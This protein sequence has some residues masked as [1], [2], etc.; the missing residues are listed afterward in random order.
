MNWIGKR[1][2]NKIYGDGTIISQDNGII[3]VRFNSAEEIKRFQCPQ[4]FEKFLTLLD[5][6]DQFVA[7]KELKQ[8]QA[9]T[10]EK[11]QK[12]VQ[13]T[14]KIIEEKQ[15]QRTGKALRKT[16]K[17]SPCQSVEEFYSLF[18]QALSAEIEVLRSE[19]GKKI[20]LRDGRK[21]NKVK[22]Q[23][24]YVFESE[25]ELP[26]PDATQISLWKG[27]ERSAGSILSC[28]EFSVTLLTRQNFGETVSELEIS[29][30]PWRLLSSLIDRLHELLDD[31]S[32]I[33]R[34]LICDGYKEIDYSKRDIITGQINTCE[35]ASSQPITFVW[36]PPGTGK[37]QTLAKIGLES[38]Q[39]G[40]RVLMLAHSNVAVDGAILRVH[41]L[42]QD[43]KPG[44]LVRYG[45]PKQQELL[46]HEYLTSY[47]LALHS[48]PKLKKERGDLLEKQRSHVLN[49]QQSL[50][51][52]TR[53]TEIRTILSEREKEIVRKAQFVATTVSKAAVDSVI[54]NSNFDVVIFD[55]ASM[56]YI[57]Q[58][59]FSASLAKKHFV[60][61]GDFRQL[62]PI[63]QS[64]E[65]SVLNADIFQYCGITS[66][67]D[68]GWS[69]KWLCM[70]D[71]Q[72]RM[73]PQISDLSS[74]IMYGSR[75]KSAE[76]MEQ[77]RRQTATVS[78][79]SGSA[80]ALV[81]LTGMMS[82]CT[83]TK[84]RSRFNVLS[85][86][87]SFA[88]AS[89]LSE[90]YEVGII[91]PYSAQSRLLHAMARDLK[92]REHLPC[93]IS[94]AT[95]H[96][97]QGSEKDVIIYDAVDCYRMA[98]PGMLL[99][100]ME[101][102][103]ANRLFN[104]AL[105]RAKGKFIGVANFAYLKN[106]GLSERL[107][108]QKV[109]RTQENRKIL[110]VEV[111][112]E[113][114]KT[115]RA[116][117]SLFSEQAGYEHFLKD[118][119]QA[120]REI[121]VEIPDYPTNTSYLGDIIQELNEAKRRGVQVYVRAECKRQLPDIVRQIAVENP[122]VA[123]PVALIDKKISWFGEPMSSAQF[124]SEGSTI[125]I[126]TRPIIRFE[127]IHTARLLNSFLG[128]ADTED[129]SKMPDIDQKGKLL[130]DNFANY[131]LQTKKCPVCGR[132]MRL[133][134]S[135]KG[136]FFLSCTGYPTC[137]G[138]ELID[139]DT[140]EKYFY[141]HKKQGQLCT[142]CHYSLEAKMGQYG[143]Y[144]QCCGAQKHKYKLDEI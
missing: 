44:Q 28:E 60:C 10:L 142:K 98:H 54:R 130:T 136:K 37:T 138:T 113:I 128:L 111:L 120:R 114:Q 21:I 81:D 87:I 61:V 40:E 29:A 126:N 23:Y 39:C 67:V 62:P 116:A 41:Q 33:T 101:N 107:M 16:P 104:V 26:Y 141:R 42:S 131:I 38:I 123:D 25:E 134:K 140:V 95:V 122:F 103:Y 115:N 108:F 52:K 19:G 12:A 17:L 59:I 109:L 86:M 91:T 71:T 94:C 121:R 48:C 1:V 13:S 65:S 93:D 15:I 96:Q 32:Y 20:S 14:M 56:A 34:A 89:H 110:G 45:Y 63:V 78:P 9:V 24:V 2:S 102:G 117:F 135:K 143:L 5:N 106:K 82:V 22:D 124:T 85:A 4:C 49:S 75:L 68:G 127:G 51:V 132:A 6:S 119:S 84:N 46:E 11:Q 58:I 43:K 77:Q 80:I 79:V 88:M 50:R 47:N 137:Q 31:P 129:K 99:T 69:H 83:K 8:I 139:V 125:S 100:S 64:G 74:R 30:E 90:K 3:S 73:H 35:M 36:G 53:L 70:L 105:T 118:I 7:Q 144:I 97:F 66:A 112:K 55:E 72:Y 133:K 57:P 18:S 27:T 92:A 76:N